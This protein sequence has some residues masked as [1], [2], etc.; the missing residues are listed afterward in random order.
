MHHLSRIAD[1][2]LRERLEAFGAVLIEGPRVT[3]GH[4][5]LVHL[6]RNEC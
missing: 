1:R 5:G 3:R 6:N 2:M 4:K